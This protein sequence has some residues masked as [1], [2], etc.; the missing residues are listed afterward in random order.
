MRRQLYTR[1]MR[2][3]GVGLIV[4]V[5]AFLLFTSSSTPVSASDTGVIATRGHTHLDPLMTAVAIA[6]IALAAIPVRRG[7]R[8]AQLTTIVILIMVLSNRFLTSGQRLVVLDQSQ[9]GYSLIIPLVLAF[10]GLFLT[11]PYGPGVRHSERTQA[12]AERV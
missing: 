9:R 4:A 12:D 2:N 6:G 11:G 7:E 3:I 10:V 1:G 8:W 5:Y